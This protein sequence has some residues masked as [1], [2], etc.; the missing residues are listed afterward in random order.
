MADVEKERMAEY[1]D[2]WLWVVDDQYVHA[3]IGADV[4]EQ[5]E[6][7][8][9]IELPALARAVSLNAEGKTAKAVKEVDS[10]VAAGLNLP[11]LH[12]TKGQLEFELGHYDQS[13]EAYEQV[14]QLRPKD[15][16]V[17]FNIGLCLERLGRLKEAASR[18]REVTALAP[19]LWV[20]HLGLGGCLLKLGDAAGALKQFDACLEQSPDHDRAVMGKAAALHMLGKI[21]EAHDLYRT[22]LRIHPTDPDLLVNLVAVAAARK[23]ERHLREYSEKLL[24]LDPGAREALEGLITAAL[25]RKNYDV[26]AHY[27][28]QYVKAYPDAYEGWFNL[29]LALKQKGNPQEAA[30]AYQQA[31]KIRPGG[32]EA[33]GNLAIIHQENE[34]FEAALQCYEKVLELDP[35]HGG[36][37]WNVALLC[38]RTGDLATAE[39][40]YAKLVEIQPDREEAWARLGY[41]LLERGDDTGAVEALEKVGAKAHARFD[42]KV[43]LAIAYWRTG[44]PAAANTLIEKA[45]HDRP[46]AVEL[47]RIQAVMAIEE[48]DP[49]TALKLEAGLAEAGETWPELSY[50]AGVLLQKANRNNEAVQAFERARKA[51]PDFGEALLNLGHAL[52]AVGQEDKAKQCWRDAVQIMPALAEDHF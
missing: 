34:D 26:A 50:D 51:K 52:K 48:Q 36:T 16:A 24:E 19:E 4:L 18:Y 33:L 41:L 7:K 11:E 35:G 1:S 29:G 13:L 38:Q 32:I 5:E 28:S 21:D 3:P 9:G 40:C 20:A 14:L 42:A 45:L 44:Q 46:N 17:I 27:G 8:R 43:N 15:K 2:H 49:D 47:L 12:W 6:K 30:S 23:N 22:V 25:F 31:V 10:A 37:L 39:T